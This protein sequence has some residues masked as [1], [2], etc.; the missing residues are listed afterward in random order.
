MKLFRMMKAAAD[1]LPEAGETFA[2]LGVRPARPGAK[3]DVKAANQTDLVRPGEG[4]M[5]VAADSVTNLLPHMR[6]PKARFP[7]WEI[8]S[9]DLGEG[10]IPMPAGPPNYVIEPAREMTLDELQTL[11]AATGGRWVCV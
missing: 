3:G 10:L 7:I 8:D 6:P 4:G 9:A 11:L 1:G 2:K 5:S